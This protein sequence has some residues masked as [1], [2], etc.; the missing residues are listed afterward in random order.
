MTA[1]DTTT[2]VDNDNIHSNT[3]SALNAYVNNGV[4]EYTLVETTIRQFSSGSRS[5]SCGI[6]VVN[7]NLHTTGG[8]GKSVRPPQRFTIPIT[9]GGHAHFIPNLYR[10]NLYGAVQ[11]GGSGIPTPTGVIGLSIETLRLSSVASTTSF[12]TG[13]DAEME[14][15]IWIFDKEDPTKFAFLTNYPINTTGLGGNWNPNSPASVLWRGALGVS[16]FDRAAVTHNTQSGAWEFSNWSLQEMWND[17]GRWIVNYRI[18]DVVSPYYIT[19]EVSLAQP[20]NNAGIYASVPGIDLA[21]GGGNTL[22]LAGGGQL[23]V[24]EAQE[25]ASVAG[26]GTVNF[27]E[28]LAML[29]RTPGL[30]GSGNSFRLAGGGEIRTQASVVELGSTGQLRLD[31]GGALAS[32]DGTVLISG[33]NTIEGLSFETLVSGLGDVVRGDSSGFVPTVAYWWR[34]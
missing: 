31:G 3:T 33:G 15:D 26:G 34:R 5:R 6:P 17:T 24:S 9:G 16:A 32:H 14:I 13:N 25:T 20:F 27:S 10:V 28:A 4:T 2:W 23:G 18:H 29:M 8:A 30:R 19:N 7:N 11:E 22:L 21:M 12:P 1:I